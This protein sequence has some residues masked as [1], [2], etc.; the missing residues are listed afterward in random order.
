MYGLDFS[1]Q[2]LPFKIYESVEP[3]NLPRET[4]QTGIT[5][6]A[7]ISEQFEAGSHEAV[8]TIKDLAR[9]LYFSAGITRRKTYPGGEI[10]FRADTALFRV[11]V[12][13]SKG[14]S[15]GRPERLFDRLASGSS[16]HSYSPSPDGKRILTHR[17]PEG[18]GSLR[19]LYFDVGFTQRL[20]ERT[21]G[22]AP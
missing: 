7:A 13:T 9:I 8:P 14:F 15:A 10:F 21:D 16:I 2:P 17:S 6:I 1:N 4:E 20:N 19:T 22:A 18:R 5:A 12:D 3:I 11:P